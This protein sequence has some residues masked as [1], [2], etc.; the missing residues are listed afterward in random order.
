[1]TTKVVNLFES[2][3]RLVRIFTTSRRVFSFLLR[4]YFCPCFHFC[5]VKSRFNESRFNA[6][7][8]FQVQNLMTKME[9]HSKKSRLSIKPRFKES[10]CADGGHSLNRDFTVF[11][12]NT[13]IITRCLSVPKV[14]IS[15]WKE[16]KAIN[17]EKVALLREEKKKRVEGISV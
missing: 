13:C 14:K 1:M 10:K 3:S 11:P 2:Y 15:C 7:S 4:G 12:E 6:K 5:T 9:F 8:Q 16:E 17:S